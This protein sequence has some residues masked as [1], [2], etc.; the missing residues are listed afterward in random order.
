MDTEYPN[1]PAWQRDIVARHGHLLHS[2]VGRDP[3][4]LLQ[5]A[6]EPTSEP[7]RPAPSGVDIGSPE[8]AQRALLRSLGSPVLAQVELLRQIEERNGNEP[9]PGAYLRPDEHDK[10]ALLDGRDVIEDFPNG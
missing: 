1:V 10:Q 6:Q 4:E 8:R 3:L 9:D 5:A 2:T 7:D